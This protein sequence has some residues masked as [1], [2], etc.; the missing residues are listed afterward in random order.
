MDARDTRACSSTDG[1]GM[2]HL[3]WS[4]LIAWDP[5]M[6]LSLGFNKGNFDRVTQGCATYRGRVHGRILLAEGAT[7]GH[8]ARIGGKTS[9][10]ACSRVVGGRLKICEVCVG[11]PGR[12]PIGREGA[13][14]LGRGSEVGKT[15]FLHAAAEGV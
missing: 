15:Q 4:F 10:Q 5:T 7:G 6:T 14:Y 3:A 8:F 2:F 1:L 11:V 9:L 12:D 13:V